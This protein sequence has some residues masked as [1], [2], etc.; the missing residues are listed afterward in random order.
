[1]QGLMEKRRPTLLHGAI[2]LHP[3]GKDGGYPTILPTEP[4]VSD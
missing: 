3:P 1:M 4:D 2:V